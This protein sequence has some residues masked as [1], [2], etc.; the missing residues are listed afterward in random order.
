EQRGLALGADAHPEH[1][2]LHLGHQLLYRLPGR[3]EDLRSVLLHPAGPG[4]RLAHGHGD[5]PEQGT[6]AVDRDR[7]GGGRALVDRDDHA[8][9]GHSAHLPCLVHQPRVSRTAA[10]S[11]GA[12]RPKWSSSMSVLPVGA[13]SD[14]PNALTGTPAPVAATV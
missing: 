9:V 8:L 13:N 4:M 10:T 6:S 2:G 12:V 7:F 5:G 11:A 1:G 14:R 3:G